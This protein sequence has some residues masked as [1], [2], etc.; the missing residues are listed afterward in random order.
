MINL[1]FIS[2]LENTISVS[3]DFEQTL[4]MMSMSINVILS[5]IFSKDFKNSFDEVI[6]LL[7]LFYLWFYSI[8]FSP[9]DW[10][11]GRP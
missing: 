3:I 1:F 7:L 10:G 11:C 4:Y 6:F 5:L 8:L 9:V 2:A